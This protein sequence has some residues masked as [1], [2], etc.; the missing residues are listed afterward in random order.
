MRRVTAYRDASQHTDLLDKA[1]ADAKKKFTRV[2]K[3]KKGP[4]GLFADLSSLVASTASALAEASVV[5]RQTYNANDDGSM[6]LVTELA[7]KG[8]WVCSTILIPS[9]KN[10]QHVFGYC[11]YMRRLAYASMLGLAAD[12]EMDGMEAARP[13]SDTTDV[14]AIIT[15]IRQATNEARLNTIWTHVSELNYPRDVVARIEKA[16]DERRSGMKS[17]PKPKRKEPTNASE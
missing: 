6:V 2:V 17:Q 16:M 9:L 11:T 7:C 8:Q 14:D 13:A 15:A 5:L 4:Y 12:E 3:N 1:L 10:P